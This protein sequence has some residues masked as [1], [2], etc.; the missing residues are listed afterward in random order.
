MLTNLLM[1]AT[2]WVDMFMVGQLGHESVAAVGLAGF[3]MT[4]FMI[5]LM[6][7]QVGTSTVVAQAHGASHQDR[8]DAG[9]RHALILG[10]VLAGVVTVIACWP[11]SRLLY[12]IFISL[13]A[14]PN[15][16]EIGALYIRIVMYSAV[17]QIVSLVGQ[18]AL[19]STGDT[20]TPLWLTGGANII[21]VILNYILIFGKFGAPELGVAGA[22]WGTAISRGLEGLSY[23]VLMNLGQLNVG[24]KLGDWSIDAELMGTLIRL[25]VPAA[26]E[27]LLVNFGFLLYNKI[28][29]G[30]GTIELAA[31]QVGVI[32]LQFSF[33]PG[34]G[35]SVAA[36][37]LVGQ[38]IGA[39]DYEQADKA[40]ISCTKL[41]CILMP[42]L[43]V[44]FVIV[45]RPFAARFIPDSPQVVPLAT[46]FIRLLAI[47]QPTMAIHFTMSG[48]LRG[49]GD[50]RSSLW[51][52]VVGMY[53]VRL[54]VSFIAAYV[55]HWSV[56]WVW[57]AMVLAHLGRAEFLYWR[58]RQ[59]RWKS[60]TL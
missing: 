20:R 54:P 40:G 7:V 6:A 11:H 50:V 30:Y 21:N 32:A 23:L 9:T 42:L 13:D 35:L 29:A 18:A 52:A 44:M 10:A 15:V 56:Y 55:F 34:F 24:L 53:C 47:S 2:Q 37:T 59:G 41:A 17:A 48:A 31:Y 36:T 12:R 16:S 5:V 45:A 39:N 19:R 1:T 22:A 27:Q 49:A 14:E 58:W 8:V 28:I 43:G 33:M 4:L 60:I 25:G 57:M 3:V 38:C 26:G 51:G 46:V